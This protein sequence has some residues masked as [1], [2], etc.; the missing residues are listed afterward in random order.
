MPDAFELPGMLRAIVPLMRREWPAGR[1]GSVIH[2]LV[3]LSDR[4]SRRACGRFA[5][6]QPGLVP[7]FATIIGSLNYLAEETAT[8]GYVD[9]VRIGWR[10]VQVINLPTAKERAVNI[11]TFT[12]TI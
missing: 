1:G 4:Y 10:A 8:L 5:R 3:A 2:E 9:T 7:R 11:P 6:F 12:F